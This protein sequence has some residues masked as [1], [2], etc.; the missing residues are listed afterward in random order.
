MLAGNAGVLER[1][2]EDGVLVT[3]GS[4]EVVEEYAGMLEIWECL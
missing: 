2:E 4:C 3:M 1:A